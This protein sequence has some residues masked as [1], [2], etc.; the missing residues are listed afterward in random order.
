M[1]MEYYGLSNLS[2]QDLPRAI[3]GLLARQNPNYHYLFAQGANGGPDFERIYLH[4]IFA[5]VLFQTFFKGGKIGHQCL[6]A[7]KVAPAGTEPSD[8]EMSAPLLA[9]TAT[10]V[11]YTILLL[12]EQS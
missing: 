1:V 9:L 3:E 10:Y 6:G 7:F 8:Y 4:P 2:M 11:A 12:Y 5:K